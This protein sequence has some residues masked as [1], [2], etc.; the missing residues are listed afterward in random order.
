VRL[1]E[2][3]ESACLRDGICIESCP[4]NLLETDLGGYPCLPVGNRGL[5]IECG[6]CVTVCPRGA[7]K[8]FIE[9]P[10]DLQIID[11]KI[12]MDRETVEIFLKGRRSFREFEEKLVSKEVVQ[13]VLDVTRWAPSLQNASFVKWLVVQSP[14]EVKRLANLATDWFALAKEVD[15]QESF[16]SDLWK[17]VPE[18][19]LRCA[20]HLVIAHA[21]KYYNL[22]EINC[23]IALTYFDL[24]ATSVGLGTCWASIFMRAAAEYPPL[25]KYLGIPASHQVY[26]SLIFGYPKYRHHRIPGRPDIKARWR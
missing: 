22:A 10:E 24:A 25:I 9:R 4:Y 20:P 2:I 16:F 7:F 11:E 21:P 14:S 1:V 15:L 6:H 19:I 3:N 26:G 13:R 5:C 23:T 12:P 17:S 8:H 18:R